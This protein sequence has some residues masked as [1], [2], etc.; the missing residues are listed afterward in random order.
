MAAFV[1]SKTHHY[2]S[3]KGTVDDLQFSAVTA[4][5]SLSGKCDFQH[6]VVDVWPVAAPGGCQGDGTP[7]PGTPH[8]PGYKVPSARHPAPARVQG[9]PRPGTPHPPGCEVPGVIHY[10]V[11]ETGICIHELIV[12]CFTWNETLSVIKQSAT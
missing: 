9:A 11:V 4:K 12:A 5:P 2:H 10:V 3:E 8:P 6:V 7:R 1:T